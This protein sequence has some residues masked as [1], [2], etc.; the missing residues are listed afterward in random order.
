MIN[1]GI[2]IYMLWGAPSPTFFN[3]EA[4]ACKEAKST[5]SSVIS[6][7]IYRTGFGCL[8]VHDPG[9]EHPL[10]VDVENVECGIGRDAK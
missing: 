8:V 2:V 5:G 1:L 6:L 9:Y 10:A 7:T 3:E 4:E